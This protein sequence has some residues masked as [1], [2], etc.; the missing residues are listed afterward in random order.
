M[1]DEF[2]ISVEGTIRGE[3]FFPLNDT[4]KTIE[5]IFAEFENTTKLVRI[6]ITELDPSKC[7]S[8]EYESKE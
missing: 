5:D 1:I 3:E 2:K 4:H 7:P 6:E 8:K